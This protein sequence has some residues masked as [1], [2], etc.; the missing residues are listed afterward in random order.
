MKKEKKKKKYEKPN[1]IYRKEIET[2]ASACDSVYTG[3]GYC[4]SAAPCL[5]LD[6]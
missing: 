4:R 5:Y 1:I 3:A 6:Q 2:L